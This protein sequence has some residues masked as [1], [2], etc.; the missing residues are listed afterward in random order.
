MLGLFIFITSSMSVLSEPIGIEDIMSIQTSG[1][2]YEALEQFSDISGDTTTA[3]IYEHAGYY[4][5]VYQGTRDMYNNLPGSQEYQTGLFNR[6][7]G[8]LNL[9][10][11][12]I[13]YP[14]TS[15]VMTYRDFASDPST[16]NRKMFQMSLLD[17]VLN[18]TPD[19]GLLYTYMEYIRMS[20]LF[21]KWRQTFL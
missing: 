7:S 16:Y 20:A 8:L 11:D 18:I 12:R 15:T 5:D 14:Y 17:E 13:Q 21:M 1:T 6:D 2:P 10:A 9:L 4:N 3:R 19:D